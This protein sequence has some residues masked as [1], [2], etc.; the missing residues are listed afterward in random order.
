MKS[1][2]SE[3]SAAMIPLTARWVATPDTDLVYTSA[4][5]LDTRRMRSPYYSGDR[6][7]AVS[8]L[9][10]TSSSYVLLAAGG[11]GKTTVLDQ[12]R[13]AETDSDTVDLLV[14]TLDSLPPAIRAATSASD[15]IF[16]DSLDEALQAEPRFALLL[17]RLI[18]QSPTHIRWRIACRPA[19]WNAGVAA[20]LKSAATPFRELDLL[21]LDRDAVALMAGA[22][23]DGFMTA[24]EHVRLTPLLARPLDVG[25][26]LMQWRASG[27]L[28]TTRS[29][30]MRYSVQRL[31]RETGA[32]F[33]EPQRQD[34]QRMVLLAE[35]LASVAMFCGTSR[36]TP[37]GEPAVP[38]GSTSAVTALPPSDDPDLVGG[39]ASVDDLREVLATS[40]YSTSAYGSV[41]IR[42]QAY[43]EFLTASLLARRRVGGRRLAALLGAD[44][45]G[46]AAG[47]MVE[48]LG[49]ML[50]MAADVP[51]ELV[52]VNA[53]ELIGTAGLELA[54]DT[55]RARIVK[56]LLDGAANGTV[57][58]GW[59]VNTTALAHPGLAG[60]LHDA[61]AAATNMWEV[62]WVA[63][64]AR[65]C[66]VLDAA[67]D[68][69]ALALDNQW[70]AHMRAEAVESFAAVAPVDRL[71][72][73]SDLLN[74]PEAED[75]DDDILAAALRSLVDVIDTARVAAAIRARRTPNFIGSYSTLLSE[76]ASLVPPKDALTILEAVIRAHG[77]SDDLNMGRLIVGLT[78]A[79]W[80]RADPDELT[81]LGQ[82]IG[83]RRQTR[84]LRR[85]DQAMP[86]VSDDRPADRLIVAAAALRQHESAGLS[87]LDLD[88]LTPA[89][90]TAVLDWMPT[91]TPEEAAATLS[92]LHQ[93]T[94]RPADA[95]TA[96][97]VLTV[98]ADHPAHEILADRRGHTKITDRPAYIQAELD[99]A[100]AQP[101]TESLIADLRTGITAARKDL[102]QWPRVVHLLSVQHAEHGIV[103][104][105][106]RW[107]LTAHPLWAHLDADDTA[108]IWEL[109]LRYLEHHRPDVSTWSVS[110]GYAN[111]ALRGWVGV[112]VLGTAALHRPDLLAD[113]PDAVWETWTPAILATPLF[114]TASDAVQ[115]IRSGADTVLRATISTAVAHLAATKPSDLMNHPW[116]DDL[117]SAAIGALRTF[118]LDEHAPGY[119]RDTA[120]VALRDREPAR[121]LT[122]A[123]V[124]QAT[125]TDPPEEATATWATLAPE[126]CATEILKEG[127]LANVTAITQL[128][129]DGLSEPTLTAFADLLLARPAPPTPT[130]TKTRRGEF[131]PNT[132]ESQLQRTEQHVL[133]VMAARG[134]V[135]D[136]TR[137]ADGP[138]A[139][140]PVKPYIRHILRRA[141]QQEAN[142]HWEPITPVA[143][144]RILANGD[145]R[146]IRNNDGL[147]T[148]LLEQLD[149]IQHDVH[150]RMLYRSV[151]DGEPDGADAKPKIED[152][153]SDWLAHELRLRLSPHVV[154]DRE[155]QVSRPKHAGIGTR[156]D[157]TVTSPAGGE[158]ARI[159][160]EAKRIEHN[161][162]LTALDDQLVDRY[163]K[164][165]GLTHGI[166][167]VYW[168]GLG[169]RPRTWKKHFPDRGTLVDTLTVQ[170]ET[171]SPE[172]HVRVAVLD[173]G[174]MG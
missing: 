106:F 11:A 65:H 172:R 87:V 103:S 171:H 82:L 152:D 165:T 80:N 133:D 104:E 33:R 4:G 12:L 81:R 67:E 142:K 132:T 69:L 28:P 60:Q 160:I 37:G 77:T 13:V 90:A 14:L 25:D 84:W 2:P 102:D 46:V 61:A 17:A 18:Q 121:A 52:D 101:T 153:I 98:P 168:V 62:F 22:D 156:I 120:I 107:D 109:G 21:P 76:L 58:E 150:E 43:A 16:I 42:H 39:T 72:D 6:P 161:E 140:R 49:W 19:S 78:A 117:D 38:D 145:A 96:D 164:P 141:R 59:G 112:F 138:A 158:L 127:T 108:S 126:E 57:D 167:L 139:G 55:T 56:A 40:L 68:L 53:R 114:D 115:A 169:R 10:D 147:M 146:L 34:E 94:H 118:A 105:Q 170:A 100:A 48:V 54:D 41:I 5:L 134:M 8:E 32:G 174:P 154:V 128:N 75:P 129:I 143:L 23:A 157:I 155:L 131:H 149:L 137:L 89:D 45:N 119:E 7:V 9:A 27:G 110:G 47:S 31:L 73:L 1:E 24:V 92:V 173:I 85:A 51:T 74:L 97:R 125:E 26:L 71:D 44:D 64:I 123:R 122:V 20:A 3:S 116:R 35:H 135:A 162:L 79:V 30:S 159:A 136:L 29:E 50:A 113:L 95:A 88:L 99:G 163:M 36:F 91:A 148:V 124:L 111:V 83:D 144:N 86:W 15:S 166:Y 66:V 93:L 63:R 70:P 130:T 151:W